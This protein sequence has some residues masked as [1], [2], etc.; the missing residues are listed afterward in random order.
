MFEQILE[1]QNLIPRRIKRKQ[2]IQRPGETTTKSYYVKSGLLRS[3][4]IDENGKEHI[5][6]F[7]PESWI[8]SDI[9]SY[10]LVVK[11][12]VFIDALED[13]T[14]IEFNLAQ[15]DPYSLINEHQ[16]EL[17]RRL[18]RRIAAMQ[19]RV[20]LLMSATAK[21]RYEYFLKTYPQLVNRVSQKFIAS[22]L[23]VTPEALSN[24]KRKMQ[25]SQH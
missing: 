22:Y 14:I 1:G 7:A 11:T 19:R 18:F 24:I 16:Q 17:I 10:A 5:I 6:M 9:E 20:I 12:D 25:H 23:G 15:L 2:I 8:I 4:I 13:S 3:Y 21:V